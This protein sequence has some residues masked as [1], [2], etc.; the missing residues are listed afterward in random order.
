MFCWQNGRLSVPDLFIRMCL[1]NDFAK[2][3]SIRM[4]H[5]TSCASL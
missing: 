2:L 4:E 5:T 1:Q 3:G